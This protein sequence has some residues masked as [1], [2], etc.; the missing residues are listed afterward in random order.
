VSEI[1][2]RPFPYPFRAALAISNDADLMS[3]DQFRMTYRYLSGC[4][5]TPLGDGLGLD[6]S[7]SMF[8]FSSPDSPNRFTLCSGLDATLGSEASLLRECAHAGIIDTLHT[9][10]D[11]STP[12]HFSRDLAQRGLEQLDRL[13]IKLEIWINHGGETNPQ[14]L[15]VAERRHFFGDDPTSPFY[16]ADITRR[17]GFRFCWIGSEISDS[18]GQDSRT[19]LPHL[20]AET[21]S[22]LNRLRRGKAPLVGFSRRLLRPLRLR[23][24]TGMLSFT[25]FSGVGAHTPVLDDLPLQLSARN[26][27]RLVERQGY[28][29]LYQHFGVRRV[30]P[31]FSAS[32]YAPNTPPYYKTEELEA[33]ERLAREFENGRI[34]VT[35]AR[36]LLR[37]HLTRQGLLW[38]VENSSLGV[39]I[40]LTGIHEPD[41]EHRQVDPSDLGGLTFYCDDPTT[42]RLVVK[43]PNAES[44]VVV[45]PNGPDNTGRKSISVPLKRS[46]SLDI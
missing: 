26:L 7:A 14:N 15:G 39:R 42:T 43:G 37:Y 31:G 6:L 23:D 35:G 41:G 10:G 27:K 1:A 29:I 16:H 3:F 19:L 12:E 34:L 36:T 44:G 20:E 24:G 13:G 46:D 8:L 30:A 25:R 21:R 5:G 38:S 45:M 22:G 18:I 40:V 28:C 17:A 9:Y 2:L 32:A 11:F 33:F 4:R